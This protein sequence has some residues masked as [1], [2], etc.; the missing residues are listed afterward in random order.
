[1][2]L[3]FFKLKQLPFRLT[4]DL[5]F[6]YLGDDRGVAKAALQ[7]AIGDGMECILVGGE[8]GVG[9]T[10]LLQDAL[11]SLPPRTKIVDIRQPEISLDEFYRATAHQLGLDLDG[12][13]EAA[14]TTEVLDFIARE[15]ADGQKILIVV[16]NRRTTA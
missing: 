16:D 9:K 8:A 1:M 6:H 10:I 2:Y 12:A 14:R 5:D 13:T 11:R 4:P 7:R 15:A 3:Q